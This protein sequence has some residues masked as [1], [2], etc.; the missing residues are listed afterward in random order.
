MWRRPRRRVASSRRKRNGTA[1]SG[2]RRQLL[3]RVR[4]GARGHGTILTRGC[5]GEDVAAEQG[6][7]VVRRGGAREVEPG[8]DLGLDVGDRL[9]GIERGDE[10]LALEQLEDRRRL[11]VVVAQARRQRLRLV[12]LARDEWSAADVADVRHLRA[13]GQ[14]VPVQPASRAQPPRQHPL[15]HHVI[16]QLEVD[17]A[18]DVVALEEELG[19]AGVAREAVEDEA[20]VPVVDG[21]PLADDRLDEVVVDQ[22]AGRHRAAHLGADLGVVLDVPAERCRRR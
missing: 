13:V 10:L 17:H 6:R 2:S 11:G 12:V 21:Q 20:V 3:G 9:R 15:V 22:L 16:G 19:L 18:V 7:C 4:G 1:G 8:A 14:E 5:H